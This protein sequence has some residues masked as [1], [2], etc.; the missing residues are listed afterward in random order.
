VKFF[1]SGSVTP[2][3]VKN[4]TY[5]VGLYWEESPEFAVRSVKIGDIARDFD[6]GAIL[7]KVTDI[8]IDDSISFVRLP[9]A[10]LSQVRHRDM[11]PT[12]LPLKPQEFQVISEELSLTEWTIR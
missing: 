6:R 10:E 1:K 5:I 9:T 11:C 8:Q 7:G 4:E 2:I 3:A 12:I